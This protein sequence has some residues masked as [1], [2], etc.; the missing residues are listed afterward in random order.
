MSE[1]GVISSPN[2]PNLYG[3]DRMC[4]WRIAINPLKNII[5]TI[6]HLDIEISH[7]C[8]RDS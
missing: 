3:N 7:K 6:E 1:E 8:Q 4:I 2:Y 5:V